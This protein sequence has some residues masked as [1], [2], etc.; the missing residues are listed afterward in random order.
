MKLVLIGVAL[1]FALSCSRPAI[2]DG[3]T[4]TNFGTTE[5]TQS[6]NDFALEK[7]FGEIVKDAKGK[8]GVAA[9]V[10]ETGQSASLNG[11]EPFAMQSVVKL[12][13]SMAVLKLVDEDRLDLDQKVRVS[14]DEFVP[15][16]MRSPLR[17]ANPDGAEITVRELI[18]YA[19]SESDGTA[20]DVLQRLAGDA[21]G[22]QAYIDSLGITDMKVKYTHKEFANQWDL[23]YW[24]RAT[25]EDALTLLKTLWIYHD[26]PASEVSIDLGLSKAS[27]DLLL[28]LMTESNN[29]DNRVKGLLPKDAVVAHKTGTGGTRDGI[30]SAT[31]DVGIITLPNN[32]HLAISVFVGD[33]SADEKTRAAVIARIAKAA[34]DRW[35]ATSVLK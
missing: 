11:N 34:W 5:E 29:P 25:P 7:E 33:S 2:T 13:I 28:R 14:K 16:N 32:N 15:S 21:K 23:Q 10:I 35:G 31:N 4:L 17:D 22:V 9:V 1:C 19:I 8:V 24:N 12:P 3:N 27:A 20:S 30:T 18:R 26:R 6:A